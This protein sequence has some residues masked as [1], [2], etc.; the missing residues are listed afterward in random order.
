[1]LVAAACN[2]GKPAAPESAVVPDQPAVSA[3]SVEPSQAPPDPVP[4]PLALRF[5]SPNIGPAAGGNDVTLDGRGFGE[6]PRI[7]FGGVQA[8]IR[9]VTPTG[10]RV[11]VPPPD[12][13]V[14]AGGTLV[15]DVTVTNPPEGSAAPVSEILTR[16]YSYVGASTGPPAAA[17]PPPA[18]AVPEQPEIAGA[19]PTA[20]DG[21][22]DE[23]AGAR[24]PTL[25]ANFSFEILTDDADCPPPNTL[26]HFTDRSTGGPTEWWWEFGDGDSSKERNS[27]HCYSAPGMRSVTLTV[28]NADELASASK[29]VTAGM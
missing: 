1:M 10:I 13:P 12:E 11:T 2:P 15:V 18:E 27:D 25:V 21:A 29:I 28:S 22:A 8:W 26:I 14:A 5:V 17:A 6:Y 4:E 23:K 16:S 9:S 3:A 7:A 24:Q 20:G 19:P